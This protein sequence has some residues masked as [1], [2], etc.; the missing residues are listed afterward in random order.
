[1]FDSIL[2]TVQR[3]KD[4]FLQ[5]P[6]PKRILYLGSILV[7]LASVSYAF[8][9]VNKPDY[10]TLYSGLQAD[11]LGR[12]VKELKASKVAYQ[13]GP[14]NTVRVPR[15]KLYEVRL[16]LASRNIPSGG[17]S[18]FEIFDKQSLGS[19]RFV[20]KI[21]Y[22]RALQGELSRTINQLDEVEESR[23]HLVIPDEALFL[24]EQ[25]PARAAVVVKLRPGARLSQRQIQG[26]VNLVSNSV[27]D[28]DEK[29]VSILSTDGRVLFKKGA[30][31]QAYGL[32]NLELEYK[33]RIE[34]ELRT[35]VQTMLQ[36]VLGPGQVITRVVADLD[37]DKTQVSE[38]SYDPDSAVIRS[39]Q[40]SIES[41]EGVGNGRP[42]GNPD[43]PINTQSQLMQDN[44]PGQKKAK[45]FERQRETVNYEVSRVQKQTVQAPG[46]IKKLSVA[47]IIDGRYENKKGAK[48]EVQRV[49][50]GRSAKELK[51]FEEL[52]KKAV[53]F[54]EGR[55]DQISVSNI[56]F[57][58][59]VSEMGA[60]QAQNRWMKML[61]DNQKILLNVVLI[62]LVF[63]LVV[64]PM[65]KILL[66][67]GDAHSEA[68]EDANV[69][70]LPPGAPA[71]PGAT[72]G[73]TLLMGPGMAPQTMGL[74]Q[75][76]A[77]LV[78]QDAE[79]A[80]EI[81]RGW[82]SEGES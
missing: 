21:N 35:K 10:V 22:Q 39:Q 67:A 24:E 69:E 26:I 58:S 30:E 52:V 50:V 48:G 54:D 7:L 57:A 42:K 23:V 32:T 81:I 59:T 33:N 46:R 68:E 17:G 2:G 36:Q 19:T 47:V 63:F 41:S 60:A 38:E 61:K 70:A 1:M 14:H 74:R 15:E 75:Q 5:L 49:F 43:A 27:E 44:P 6:A 51:A 11:D 8:Y 62:A 76:A 80:A 45:K 37:F 31:G 16:D 18:G 9:L 4:S 77:A 72:Q 34:S 71:I 13:L 29:N 25:K 28:L 65:M 82:L 53:G 12:V 78:Q 3:L 40:R 79:R 20:Q 56:P 64:R 66:Q 55:G 73:E